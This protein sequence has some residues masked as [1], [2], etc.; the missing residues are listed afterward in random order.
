[1]SQMLEITTCD[2]HG[3]P[4]PEDGWQGFGGVLERIPRLVCRDPLSP[5]GTKIVAGWLRLCS[6]HKDCIALEDRAMPSRVIDV[7]NPQAPKLVE[8]KSKHGQYVILSHCWGQEPDMAKLT[9]EL[10]PSFEKLIEPKSLPATFQDAVTATHL[11]GFRFLWIDALCIV[12]DD[13][14]DWD[15][16]AA[17]MAEYYNN[18]ALTISAS[19]SSTCK[20]GFLA[21]RDTTKSPVFGNERKFCFRP[22]LTTIN[23]MP[24]MP[25]SR[26]AWTLQE[27]YLS[28][29]VLHFFK[30][31]MFFE[32]GTD[33]YFEGY[34][35]NNPSQTPFIT[36]H[37][38]QWIMERELHLKNARLR[39]PNAQ[40]WYYSN[41]EFQLHLW[42]GFV[43][44][45]TARNIT[46]QSDRLPAIAGMANKFAH[47][48]MGEY[49]AG[50]WEF[51]LFRGMCW[52]REGSTTDNNPSLVNKETQKD[53]CA[54]SWSWAGA[55]G[56]VTVDKGLWWPDRG[57]SSSQKDE[58]NHWQEQ[59]GPY[60]V[61]KHLLLAHSNPYFPICE[62]SFIE[63][64]GYCR[65]VFLIA[66][67]AG[68]SKP[69]GL[70]GIVLKELYFDTASTAGIVSC[71]FESPTEIQCTVRKL[72]ML[73]ICKDRSGNRNVHAL[74]LE[75]Q[76]DRSFKR[77]GV[78]RLGNYN[79]LPLSPNKGM[80]AWGFHM[81]PRERDGKMHELKNQEWD[82]SKW[83][84]KTLR[85]V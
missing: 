9:K 12:Q 78:C 67:T 24:T 19:A 59:Y 26:R 81:H 68:H 62:G 1:M 43:A 32:C 60:L 84:K 83:S 18:S 54:P 25:I 39:E 64:E 80:I 53:Y 48:K 31:Q 6:D 58:Y 22:K 85:L 27:R 3:Q 46:F 28:P 76:S 5:K 72:T 8:T 33:R 65:S 34:L 36:K 73:Q 82:P 79:L 44:D 47:P 15:N 69:A 21:P 45:F 20:T 71:Y 52:I 49:M 50:L 74:L 75:P 30:D 42:Y 66:Q 55:N 2:D 41:H 29:R 23:H 16:E 61:A 77:V 17:K 56:P 57:A 38:I 11:L 51:D 40:D 37:R 14:E 10:L 7:K 4:V 70:R 35:K 13:T 63:V